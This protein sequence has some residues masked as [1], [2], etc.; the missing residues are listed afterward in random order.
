VTVDLAYLI[1]IIGC[2]IGLAGWLNGRDKH[3]ERDAEWRGSV[4]AKLNVI[5]GI[6]SEVAEIRGTVGNHGERLAAVESSAK[7]AHLRI[8][9]ICKK[10]N[11]VNPADK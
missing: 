9:D 4:D 7:Q 2:L 8:D 11:P 10:Q 5:V 6:G 3:T 1:A